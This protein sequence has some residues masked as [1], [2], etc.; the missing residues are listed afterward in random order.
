M[1][2]CHYKCTTCLILCLIQQLHIFHIVDYEKLLP[3][4]NVNMELKLKDTRIKGQ[5]K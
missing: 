4:I 3:H 2:S 1:C 5:M